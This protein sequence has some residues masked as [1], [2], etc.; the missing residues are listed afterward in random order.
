MVLW[1][2]AAWAAVWCRRLRGPAK[3]VRWVD[4]AEH[5]EQQ[6]RKRRMALWHRAAWAAVWCRR[7][8][9]PAKPVRWVDAAEREVPCPKCSG[10]AAAQA[11]NAPGTRK[12]R[13]C[14]CGYKFKVVKA[15]R[16]E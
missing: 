3:P 16:Y 15:A 11:A 9:G 14:A 2:R 6:G 12:A 10:V 1:H 7:L 4:A 5:C 13:C 8:R